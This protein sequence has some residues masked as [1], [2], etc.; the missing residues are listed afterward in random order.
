MFHAG[1]YPRFF[2]KKRPIRVFRAETGRLEPSKGIR[3]KVDT[4]IHSSY[5]MESSPDKSRPTLILK[6]AI[7]AGIDGKIRHDSCIGED[8]HLYDCMV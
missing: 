5:S 6:A 7:K 2:G 8:P 4:H 3:M 1:V